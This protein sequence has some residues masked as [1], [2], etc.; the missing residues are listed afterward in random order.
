MPFDVDDFPEITEQEPNNDTAAAQLLKPPCIVNG[1]ID[2]RGDQDVF[3]FEG[4]RGG[5][6]ALEVLAAGDWVRPS[7]RC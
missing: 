5:Q 3:R 4:R 7:T 2:Q 6:I 1:R